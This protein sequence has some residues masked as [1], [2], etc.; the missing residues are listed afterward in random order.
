MKNPTKLPKGLILIV[1]WFILNC[2]S[3]IY[4]SLS[5]ISI[6]T[7]IF[8]VLLLVTGIGLIKLNNTARIATIIICIFIML[9]EIFTLQGK[10]IVI[11][12]L[13]ILISIHIIYYLREPKIK[14][15]FKP[16]ETKS[17]R[18]NITQSDENNTLQK[19]ENKTN[20]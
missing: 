1:L 9:F 18:N 16:L 3:G 2:I 19:T 15:L 10:T 6:F 4:V 7:G 20:D 5:E 14:I 8:S 11:T 17:F 13:S 12:L